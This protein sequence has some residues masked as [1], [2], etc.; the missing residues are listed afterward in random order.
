[1]EY[2]A[3]GG[4]FERKVQ[5]KVLAVHT[6]TAYDGADVSHHTFLILALDGHYNPRERTCST[7]WLGGWVDLIDG[8][9]CLEKTETSCTF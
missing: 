1:V 9:N 3:V 8:L 5:L 2:V 7:H 4:S 6:T